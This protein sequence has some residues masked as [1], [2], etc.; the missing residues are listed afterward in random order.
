M[1]I[2]RSL[3]YLAIVMALGLSFRSIFW[4]PP[5]LWFAVSF[6][7]LFLLVLGAGI[8]S[9]ELQMYCDFL[10]NGDPTSEEIA[11][12]FDDG[13]DPE[14]TPLV[15]DALQQAGAVAT[16]FVIGEKAKAHPELIKRMIAEGH[17]VALHSLN[18]DRYLAARTQ[19]RIEADIAASRKII[20]ELTGRACPWFRPPIGITSPTMQRAISAQKVSL[21]AWSMRSGDGV[22]RSTKKQ[23]RL[24]LSRSAKAGQIILLHDAAEF[25][26][27]KPAS[28]E[29]LPWY[30]GLLNER[31]LRTV[32]IEK[33]A[34]PWRSSLTA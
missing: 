30:L 20:E 33:W 27:R 18:H 1:P 17:Q 13:P 11:L 19:V 31:K 2:G 32:T 23:L 24:R 4:D 10:I 5:E 6:F 3:L 25:G 8:I 22:A 16:F 12:T 15:L 9:P 21:I 26:G 34:E 28:I 29:L 7:A 14:T